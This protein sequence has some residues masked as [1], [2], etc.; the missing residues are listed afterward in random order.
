MNPKNKIPIFPLLFKS[1]AINKLYESVEYFDLKVTNKTLKS[2]FNINENSIYS[3]KLIPEYFKLQLRDSSFKTHIVPQYNWGYSILL[4]PSDSIESF[5]QRQFNSKKRNIFTR[6]VKRLE[7]CFDVNYK[8]YHGEITKP[9]YNKLMQS[10]YSMII[11]RFK[12]RKELHKNLYEWEFLLEHTYEDII[13]KEASLFV[14]YNKE[15]PIEISLNYHFDKVLFSYISSYN[16]DYSKFGLGHVEIYKQIEWCAKNGYRLFEMGV[17]GMD[18][19][20]RWSNNIYRYQHYIVNKNS[21]A[22]VKMMLF[23][24]RLKEYLKSK[25]VNE[26][27]AK[28]KGIFKTKVTKSPTAY[29]IEESVTFKKQQYKEI[30]CN[31]KPYLF[32]NKHIYNFIYNTADHCNKVKVYKNKTEHAFIIQG[33]KQGQKIT[34]TN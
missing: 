22:K 17:G 30:D 25:G 26:L 20:R 12:E 13:N 31:D 5:M 16:I 19:K 32:L 2:N 1:D 27:N 11:S 10:L 6:Y 9:D 4:N 28:L 18:Y 15:Q 24:I 3:F 8:M 33:E 21:T 34:F 14:I 23:K 7:T 29:K